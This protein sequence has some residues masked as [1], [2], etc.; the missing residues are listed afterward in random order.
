MIA[1]KILQS[2]SV[3]MCVCVCLKYA[4]VQ[5]NNNIECTCCHCTYQVNNF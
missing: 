2:D 1:D 5:W 3:P 4:G